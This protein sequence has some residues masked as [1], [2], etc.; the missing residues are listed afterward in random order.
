MRV[1]VVGASGAIGTRLVPQLIARGHVV[2]GT[3]RSPS[4]EARI[5]ALGAEPVQM[6][7]LDEP[8]VRR[9]VLAAHPDAIIHQATAL[10]DMREFKN[11]DRGFAQTNRLR[12]EGTDTLLAAAR[13]AKVH[14]FIARAS[15]ARCTSG[16]VAR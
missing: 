1:L 11:F 6:D 3:H 15:P 9:A 16:P 10:A 5:R 4:H 7:L 12:T 8:V 14:R 2:I 13:E